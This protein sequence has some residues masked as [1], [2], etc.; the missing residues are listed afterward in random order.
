LFPLNVH[1][2]VAA[3]AVI[4]TDVTPTLSVA[5]PLTVTE[6]ETVAP[7][8]GEVMVTAGTVVSE[9]AEADGSTVM[10]VLTASIS[11]RLSVTVVQSE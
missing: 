7:L 3:P 4:V 9:E 8:V 2:V 10:Y 5:V 6:P 11:P 1:G